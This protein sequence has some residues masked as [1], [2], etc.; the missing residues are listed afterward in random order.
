MTHALA[1]YDRALAGDAARV[2]FDDGSEFP[3]PVRRYLGPIDAA[4]ERMLAG[5]QGPVLDVGCG[6]GRHLRALSRRGVFALG[7]DISEQAVRLACRD[8][9]RAV[10]ADVFGELPGS[11]QTALLLDGNIGIGGDPVRLLRRLAQLLHP[12]GVVL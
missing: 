6:P 9:A 8:G 10:V 2:N 1:L 4:D 12:T 7:V 11:W 5:V 3:L